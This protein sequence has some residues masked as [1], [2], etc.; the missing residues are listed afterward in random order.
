MNEERSRFDALVSA[1]C[2]S[3]TAAQQFQE[4]E[5]EISVAGFV[6]IPEPAR[7]NLLNVTELDFVVPFLDVNDIE[8]IDSQLSMFAL[9]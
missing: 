9:A 1:A 6:L 7:E 5:T 2:S 3:D 4:M 8:F